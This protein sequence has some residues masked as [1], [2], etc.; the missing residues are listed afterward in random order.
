MYVRVMQGKYEIEHFPNS[1]IP[2]G[3]HIFLLFLFVNS[4]QKIRNRSAYI[5]INGILCKYLMKSWI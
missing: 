3:Y 5:R 1:I 4:S 2:V